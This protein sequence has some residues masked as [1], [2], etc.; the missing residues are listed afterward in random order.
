MITLLIGAIVFYSYL[1]YAIKKNK[2]VPKSISDTFYINYRLFIAFM[3][4]SAGVIL[5]T[6]YSLKGFDVFNWTNVGV[7]FLLGVPCFGNMYERKVRKAHLLSASLGFTLI[8]LGFGLDYGQWW[9]T[10]LSAVAGT[11]SYLFSKKK[12]WALEVTLIT[13]MLAMYA[14]L[15]I[16]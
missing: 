15:L 12:V 5:M 9:M 11:V 10:I 14:E 2:G 7:F 4:V 8:L 1:A 3:M 16:H 13:C 6:S